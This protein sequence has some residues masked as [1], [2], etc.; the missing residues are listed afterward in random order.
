M[1]QYVPVL[2]FFAMIVGFGLGSLGLAALVRPARPQPVKLENYECGPAPIGPAWIR[3]PVGFYLVALVFVVFDALAV[4]L[5]PWALV[6]RG[7]TRELGWG[8]FWPMAGF[9]GILLL[10]WLYAYREGV[11]SWQ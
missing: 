8:V 4:F 6:L 2:V 1:P 9:L 7:L 10:G 11:L 5:F 3:F